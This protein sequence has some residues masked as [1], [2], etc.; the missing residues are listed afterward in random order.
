MT[1]H[2]AAAEGVGAGERGGEGWGRRITARPVSR[3]RN[4]HELLLFRGWSLLQVVVSTNQRRDLCLSVSERRSLSRV[5]QRGNNILA[6]SIFLARVCVG[7]HVL[8]TCEV[9]ASSSSVY[10]TNIFFLW[11][12]CINAVVCGASGPKISLSIFVQNKG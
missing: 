5:S 12:C 6:S 7:V 3:E 4:K 2:A 1:S 11:F 9:S 8:H 10:T